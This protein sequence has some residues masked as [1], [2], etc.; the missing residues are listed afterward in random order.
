[1]ALLLKFGTFQDLSGCNNAVQLRVVESGV[2]I[3]DRHPHFTPAEMGRGP[4]K[5]DKKRDK[6]AD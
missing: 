4:P 2:G 3:A 6:S 1:M 5:R